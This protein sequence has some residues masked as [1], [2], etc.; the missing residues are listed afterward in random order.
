MFQVLAKIPANGH[1]SAIALKL[2]LCNIPYR[3][4]Q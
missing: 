1:I 3:H 4:Q 2:L